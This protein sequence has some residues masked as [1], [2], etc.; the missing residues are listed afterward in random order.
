MNVEDRKRIRHSLK[1]IMAD[2][3]K[4][5]M[6]SAVKPNWKDKYGT[7]LDNSKYNMKF[8]ELLLEFP[9]VVK[10]VNK[11]GVDHVLPAKENPS[12][13][14]ANSKRKTSEYDEHDEHDYCSTAKKLK[15]IPGVPFRLETQ[16]DE[17]VSAGTNGMVGV[18]QPSDQMVDG[19]TRAALTAKLMGGDGE[20]LA[21]AER[22]MKLAKKW[23][24][25]RRARD[26]FNVA[27]TI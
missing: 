10:L 11:G 8:K 20:K 16:A 19:A 24:G 1:A 4:G 25:R 9:R 18:G 13:S 15:S 17:Y 3:P 22:N 12:G 23:E 26:W 27:V 7:S 5:L 14:S 21:E 6:L 2:H